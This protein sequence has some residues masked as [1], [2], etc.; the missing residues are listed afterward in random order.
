MPLFSD[1]PRRWV[2][3]SGSK[4]ESRGGRKVAGEGGAE[5]GARAGAGRGATAER[6]M[7]GGTAA[8]H[9]EKC[10]VCQKRTGAFRKNATPPSN[11][12]R[13]GYNKVI[14]LTG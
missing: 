3:V 11:S 2:L 1:L 6:R 14:I 12:G 8:G 7:C 10:N 5:Q 4:A 13:R 9:R